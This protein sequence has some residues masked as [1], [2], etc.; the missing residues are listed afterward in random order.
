MTSPMTVHAART[1]YVEGAHIPH[2]ANGIRRQRHGFIHPN[3]TAG[4][5][6]GC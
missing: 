1:W 5:V 2:G 3:A 6:E 4:C